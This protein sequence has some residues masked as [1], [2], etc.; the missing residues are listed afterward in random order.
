[1]AHALLSASGSKIWLSCT[2]AARAQEGYPDQESTYSREGSF[3][4]DL[5][6]ARLNL[7]LGKDDG[8]ELQALRKSSAW[9]E[10]YTA[11][12]EEAVM[13]Y[14]TRCLDLYAAVRKTTPDALALVEQR[15]DYSPW[16]VQGFGTGDFLVITDD[17]IIVRDLKL[18]RGVS[19]VAE[20]NSQL[21]LYAAGA[22]NAYGVLYGARTIRVEIDQPRLGNLSGAEF[23]VAELSAWLE[24]YVVPRAT[25]A[26]NGEGEFVAGEHCRFCRARHRCET[27]AN[28]ALQALGARDAEVDFQKVM[29]TIS[30]ERLVELLPQLD[31]FIAWASD[32]KE[33]ALQQHVSGAHRWPGLKL[34]E[35]RSTRRLTNQD[36]AAARLLK[37]GVPDSAIYDRVMLPLTKL[38]K[39]VGKGEFARLVGDLIEKPPGAPRLVPESDPRP[40]Y[41]PDRA[42]AAAD[43]FA[44]FD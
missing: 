25:L 27:R 4:H 23:D 15:L 24:D 9:A 40:E 42:S 6:S 41:Q 28:A 34:V 43:A 36:E 14:V 12:I 26:W 10:F 30:D 44:E 1:M 31:V 22:L 3:G 29:P 11:E 8:S 5:A 19:V 20:D 32:M 16:V 18:G 33:W 38:E 39:A 17:L 37:A 2:P 21:K 13:G 35:G 7:A